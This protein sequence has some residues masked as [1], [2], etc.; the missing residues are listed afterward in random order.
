MLTACI[1]Y[2]ELVRN[3]VDLSLTQNMN[4]LMYNFILNV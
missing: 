3:R 2:S 4:S 1:Q